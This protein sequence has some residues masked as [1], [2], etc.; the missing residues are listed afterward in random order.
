MDIDMWEGSDQ[1]RA[2]TLVLGDESTFRKAWRVLV[3]T[4]VKVPHPPV[5]NTSRLSYA[6][7]LAQC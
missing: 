3:E 6:T 2:L 7:M 5:E 4:S 1:N